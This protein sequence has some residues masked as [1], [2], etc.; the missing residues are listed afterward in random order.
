MSILI[1]SS[2]ISIIVL[3]KFYYPR[4][5]TMIFEKFAMETMSGIQ[6]LQDIFVQNVVILIMIVVGQVLKNQIRNIKYS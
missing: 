6:K 1:A 5:H 3:Y 2:I 4:K